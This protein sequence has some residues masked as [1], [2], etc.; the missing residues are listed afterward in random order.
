MALLAQVLF[1]SP[2]YVAVLHFGVHCTCMYSAPPSLFSSY[3]SLGS[4]VLSSQCLGAEPKCQ[5]V[6]D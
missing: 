6:Q 3:V 4:C 1:H 2:P 5:E